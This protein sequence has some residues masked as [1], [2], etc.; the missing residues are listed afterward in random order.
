MQTAREQVFY[1]LP[2][3]FGCVSY[4]AIDERETHG[5]L[6]MIQVIAPDE[7][8]RLKAEKTE[9]GKPTLAGVI[10]KDDQQ[11]LVFHP[12]PDGAYHIDAVYQPH[13]KKL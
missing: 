4:L 9:L 13:L 8:A 5:V 11:F 12:T 10:W 1:P 3:D 6:R 7:M 2:D